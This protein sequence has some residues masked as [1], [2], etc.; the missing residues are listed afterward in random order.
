MAGMIVAAQPEAAE[1]GAQILE[2]GG[3][4]IDAAIAAAF[5]QGVVDPQMS[6]LGGFGSMQIYMPKRSFHK[7]LEFYA[8]A[9][10]MV[11]P[12]MW[13]AKVQRQSSDGFAFLLDDHAN[14]IGYLA[15]GVPGSVKGYEAALKE[16]GSMPWAEVLA[17]AIEQANNG[18][19]VR[20]HVHW[21]WAQDQSGEGQINT[22]AK[23]AFSETGRQVY[24]RA[25]G[26]LKRPGDIV[27]NPD[28]ARTLQ[29]LAEAGPEIFYNGEI[30]DAMVSDM[31]ANQGLMTHE[32]LSSYNVSWV[33]PMWATYRGY[34]IA[35]NPPPSSGAAL[36]Q[37]LKIMEHFDLRGMEHS[38]VE[39]VRLLGEA[40]KRMTIDK[41]R[42]HGDPDFSPIP[43]DMLFSSQ[44][45][46]E[47]AASIRRGER[48]SV[49]RYGDGK[50]SRDTT[51]VVAVDKD[52]NCATLTHT[53]ASPSGVITPGLGFMYNGCM[54]RF[55]PR[56]GHAGSL[57]PGKRRASSQAPTI[58]FREG[59]PYIVIG[60]PGGSYIAPSLAQG[61]MNVIDFDMSIV[62][63]ISAPRVMGVSDSIEVCNRVR[64]SV[65]RA[66]QDDGYSV[67]RSYQS[68][69][70]AALHG[71]RIDR[72]VLT[73]AADPQRD[74]M[75]LL[76]R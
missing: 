72:D 41:E 32:D 60:A 58:V 52:G 5:M 53:N 29:R 64:Q 22:A 15:V 75:A 20:P 50:E 16:C 25:D 19:M 43:L 49:K 24:F 37:L 48:A 9:P 68:Y 34:D 1:A 35:T 17:P 7:T 21:Y 74:G 40:M 56:P 47:L 55:D 13:T 23:L 2:R 3:N 12:D 8:R 54:S 18:F 61:I 71:I 51:H 66:L 39:H 69:A 65:T 27:Y 28:L 33:D 42:Y 26:S 70:F 11:R 76:V 62:D 4:A 36:L 31:L 63:A 59:K 30:A 14:E 45:S 67:H 73:G 57:A 38:S 6:G 44:Y 46:G 10:L